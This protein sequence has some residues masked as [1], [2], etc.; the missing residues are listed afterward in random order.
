MR[1]YRARRAQLHDADLSDKW[2]FDVDG[3][4]VAV[5]PWSPGEPSGNGRTTNCAYM[6]RDF[7]KYGLWNDLDC[8]DKTYADSALCA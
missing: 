4:T 3:S 1:S 6:T 5:L 7:G 8:E 2:E